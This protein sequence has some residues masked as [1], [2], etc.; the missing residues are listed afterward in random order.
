MAAEPTNANRAHAIFVAGRERFG[1]VELAQDVFVAHL[2]RLGRHGDDPDLYLACAC[3]EGNQDAHAE[4]ERFVFSQ[5]PQFIGHVD[6]SPQTVDEIRQQLRE[7]LLVR[8]GD[9][10]P[11]IA[12]YAGLGPLGAWV[13]IAALRLALDHASAPRH[14]DLADVPALASPQDPELAA[15]RG[16]YLE[17]YQ[18]ALRDAVGALSANERSLLRLSVVDGVSIDRLSELYSVHRATAARRLISAKNHLLQET[19][20]LLG[21]RLNLPIGEL[22]SLA[23]L[24]RSQ[25]HLSLER[26]L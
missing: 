14:V 20:R 7:R 1:Q 25:L 6:A 23:P 4:L 3:A 11:R 13:R 2:N 5:V 24:L 22:R 18:A 17:S 26:L 10:A 15:I 19:Y 12:E 9:Q 8:R 16:K 21:A